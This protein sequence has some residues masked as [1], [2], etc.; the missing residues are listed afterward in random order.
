MGARE[1]L[2]FDLE[3]QI[4]A[5]KEQL[6]GLQQENEQLRK[7]VENRQ[8]AD[9]IKQDFLANMSHELRTPLNGI[10][11]MSEVMKE[12]NLDME[13]R[14][15]LDAIKQ[16][17]HD[18]LRIVNNL[19]D[20]SS[21]VR[22]SLKLRPRT[23]YLRPSLDPVLRAILERC[24]KKGLQ[25]KAHIHDKVPDRVWGDPDRLQQVVLNLLSNSV[26]FTKSGGVEFSIMPWEIGRGEQGQ[27]IAGIADLNISML[28]FRISDTGIGIPEEKRTNL[29]EA[30]NLNEEL[31]TKKYAGAGL[32]LPIAMH[33][34]EMM[35]GTIWFDTSMGQGTTFHFTTV[36]EMPYTD[37]A[38]MDNNDKVEPATR[39][40]NVLLVED[41]EVSRFLAR[42][43][44][45]RMG[46]TVECAE[47]GAQALDLLCNKDFDL[48]LMDIQMPTMDGITAVREIRKQ[49]SPVR[50]SSIPVVALTVFSM[51]GDKERFMTA[52]MDDYLTKPVEPQRLERTIRAA[53]ARRASVLN[54][55]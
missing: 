36:F 35:G 50:D 39:R 2:H 22:G 8:S 17:G 47:N 28:H 15:Y 20:L 23:F 48:V 54:P 46:H 44:L 7:S 12:T 16:C 25:F 26:K 13:Q 24:R 51:Q 29:F 33:L 19:L 32:G 42:V 38:K 41:E 1:S 52:G 53:M 3:R 4:V 45:T 6:S 43:M 31:L 34:V 55:E 11:G 9:K 5:L 30:F 10:L 18:L 40:L 27:P 14:E 49:G 21:A 37:R